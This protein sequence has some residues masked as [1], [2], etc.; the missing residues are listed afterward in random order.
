MEILA[1]PA[2]LALGSKREP[3]AHERA[4]PLGGPAHFRKTLDSLFE[5]LYEKAGQGDP[6]INSEML[7]LAKDIFGNGKRDI[8]FFHVFT[9]TTCPFSFQPEANSLVPLPFR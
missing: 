8:L 4:L 7:G 5:R 1:R 2:G 6:P 3:A 9:C